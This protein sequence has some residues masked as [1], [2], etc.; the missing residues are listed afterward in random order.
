MT[1][2]KIL[3]NPDGLNIG[4]GELV[5][6]PDQISA[7]FRLF[8]GALGGNYPIR[9]AIAVGLSAA[10]KIFA[11]VMTVASPDVDLWAAL[12]AINMLYYTMAFGAFVFIPVLST[13]RGIP[14]AAFHQLNILEE[15]MERGNIPAAQRRMIWTSLIGKYLAGITPTFSTPP[16]LEKLLAEIRADDDI[17]PA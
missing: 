5:P 9:L 17:K 7:L 11:H 16:N 2:Q 6:S 13:R 3:K 8:T 4:V 14:E 1:I 12:N 10:V 15:M